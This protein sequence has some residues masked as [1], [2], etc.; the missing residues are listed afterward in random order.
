MVCLNLAIFLELVVLGEG[1]WTIGALAG[2]ALHDLGKLE[3]H[4]NRR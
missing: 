1:D 3:A 4:P 2:G